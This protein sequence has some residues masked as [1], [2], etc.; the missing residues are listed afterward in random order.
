MFTF[1]SIQI[2]ELPQ[3]EVPGALLILAS[4]RSVRTCFTRAAFLASVLLLITASIA[5]ATCVVP[6]SLRARL[7]SKPT[8]E[9]YAALGASFGSQKN[10]TCAAD[11]YAK[12]VKLQPDSASLLYLLGLSL[13]SAGQ[14]QNATEPLRNAIR[15]APG[16]AKAHLALAAALDQ[17]D[18]IEDAESEWRAAL[19]L[20]PD[21]TPALDGLS[22]DLIEDRDYASVI[23]LL[24]N[25]ARKR[26]RS[27]LQLLNLGMAYIKSGQLD[28][29]SKVLHEGLNASPD[30]L[31]L[32]DELSV[33]LVLQKRLNEAV[34][35]L[36]SAIERHPKDQDT[37]ILYLRALVTNHVGNPQQVAQKLLVAY[38]HNWEVLYLNAVLEFEDGRL[39]QAR[40]HLVESV[41]LNPNNAQSRRQFGL[42]LMQL[43][44][45]PL[46]KQQFQQAIALGIPDSEVYLNLATVLKQLGETDTAK[47]Q[48]D[49]Y[50][51]LKKAESGRG[52][53]AGKAEQADQLMASGDAAQAAAL[54]REALASDPDEAVLAYKLSRAL[55]KANDPAGQ[56][57]A[58][59]RAIEINPNLAEAQNELGYLANRSGDEHQAESYFRAAIHASPSYIVAWVNLAATLASQAKWQDAN[60]ALKRA[61]AINPTDPTARELGQA[62]AAA[63]AQK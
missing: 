14:P 40:A 28:Q 42:V 37:Q 59:L 19:T 34:S 57:A 44:E 23:A 51:Q 31:P 52:Q 48:L 22:R 21:S 8:A 32:A 46:A 24:E 27:A 56:K 49:R 4:R 45:L 62:I 13:F 11:A 53:A 3:M 54:Y 7:Q 5:G 12:A 16:N 39:R 41:S 61:L 15:L 26:V 17:L 20:D 6:A 2:G 58:L 60:D 47:E 55:D 36:E 50:R 33:V 9:A 30:S 10:F 35:V 18:Q 29:A 1:S 25:P 63:Q 43:Q 38:P